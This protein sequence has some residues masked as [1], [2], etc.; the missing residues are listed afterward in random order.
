M[1]DFFINWLITLH[2]VCSDAWV[3]LRYIKL[4][5]QNSNRMLV[6]AFL[7]VIH[8]KLR[9]I[10]YMILSIKSFLFLVMLRFMRMSSH[11]TVTPQDKLVDPFVVIA[12]PKPH[13][14][15]VSMPCIESSFVII[16]NLSWIHLWSMIQ[17]IAFHRPPLNLVLF[18]MF[19]HPH[20][21]F[22]NLLVLLVDRDTLRTSIA[23]LSPHCTHLSTSLPQ[24]I[25]PKW[26]LIKA[27]LR[28]IVHLLSLSR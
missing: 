6:H 27:Y 11:S 15:E 3:L 7:W 28:L 5:G 2:Y 19:R 14:T 24:I 26:L 25:F 18:M 1:R 13:V 9:D 10:N 17:M 8:Q 12:L 20:W 22:D 4:I 16:R 23:A 21:L